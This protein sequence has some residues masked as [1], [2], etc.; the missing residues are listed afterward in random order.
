[1]KILVRMPNWLG[2]AVMATPALHNLMRHFSPM[3]IILVGSA[4]VAEMFRPD[5]AYTAVYQDAS[6]LT[7]FRIHGLWQLARR[8]RSCHGRVDVAFA[9]PNSLSA[10]LLLSMTRA[11]ERVGACRRWRN[12]WLS[13]PVP[14]SLRAH[15]ARVYNQI[16]NGYLGTDYETGPA[17]LYTAQRHAYPRGTVGI[18]PGAAYGSAKRW[19][20]AGFAHV[21]RELASQYDIAIFGSAAEVGM[22]DEM[23]S[24]L[25]DGGVTHVSNLAGRTTIPQLVSMIAG[26]D[27]LVTNDSGP[28][29]I[30]AAFGVPTVAIFGPTDPRTTCPWRNERSVIVRHD[31][32]CAPCMKRT[33]PLGHHA[34]MK[35]VLPE[36]VLAATRK[37]LLTCSKAACQTSRPASALLRGLSATDVLPPS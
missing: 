17:A 22:A 1:M 19:E 35:E 11:Q 20:L 8:I 12:A 16:V 23:E 33:C 5:P 3:E 9:F 32:P 21:A 15:Q 6:R 27:L 34:C 2:D 25:R 24:R 14:V 18:N 36:E 30:A 28:M 29:H 13:H 7:R 10:R 4:A 37:L 26:L 31:L